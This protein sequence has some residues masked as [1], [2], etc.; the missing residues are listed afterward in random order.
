MS[1]STLKPILKALPIHVDIVG[2]HSGLEIVCSFIYPDTIK[3]SELFFLRQ[4]ILYKSTKVLTIL[5]GRYHTS[6]VK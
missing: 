6:Q 5:Q 1:K 3:H 2:K 4:E